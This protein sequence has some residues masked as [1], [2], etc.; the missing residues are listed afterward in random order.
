M[1]TLSETCPQCGSDDIEVIDRVRNADTWQKENRCICNS[2]G[3]DWHETI[4]EE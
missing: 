4:E 2:C 1:Y 3:Y